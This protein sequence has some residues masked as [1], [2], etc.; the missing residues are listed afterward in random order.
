YGFDAYN[1]EYVDMI[2]KGIVDPTKVTRSAL[3]NAASIASTVL[4]T[5][6]LVADKKEENPAPAAAAPGGMGGMY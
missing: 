1:E 5:E 2:E 4:T 3:Q 6:A